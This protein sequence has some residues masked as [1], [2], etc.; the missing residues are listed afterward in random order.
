MNS[1]NFVRSYYFICI[2]YLEIFLLR[3]IIAYTAYTC[4]LIC[5]K[6]VFLCR[7]NRSEHMGDYISGFS[8]L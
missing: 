1:S 4:G 6:V 2:L 5:Q 7:F 3:K 8:R